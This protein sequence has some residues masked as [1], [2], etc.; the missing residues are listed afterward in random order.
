MKSDL[1]L[2]D[3]D[4]SRFGD[5]GTWPG[6]MQALLEQQKQSWEFLRRGYESLDAIEWKS[7]EITGSKYTVQWNRGRLAS[8][9][10]QVDEASIRN[11]ACFLCTANLPDAQRGVAYGED[12]L[13]LCNPYPIFPEHFTVA[14]REHKPQQI[15]PALPALARLAIDLEGHY[16]LLYNGPRCGASAPDHLHV[17]A[18]SSGFLPIEDEYDRIITEAG[19]KIADTRGLLAFGVAEFLRPFISLECDD[20]TLLVEGFNRVYSAMRT[21]AAENDEPMMNLL[22]WFHEGEWKVLIF[23]RSKHRPSFY[24]EEGEGRILISPAAVDLGGVITA[25]LE[26]DFRRLTPGHI[27]TMFNE[28]TLPR[29]RF[30]SLVQSVAAG[31]SS[32]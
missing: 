4:L 9:S 32:L 1:I 7:F 23:P 19:E 26:A 13:I 2:A 10:A 11:R 5:T 28:V 18:G 15:L 8:S 30:A 25:P 6:K 14:H 16:T 3:T 12:Y 22:L 20:E 29:D 24:F 17:Q 31:L 27:V 21:H